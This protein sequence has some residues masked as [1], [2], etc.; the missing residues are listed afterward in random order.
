MKK[1]AVLV[2]AH[3]EEKVI[4]DTLAS[5]RNVVDAED[6]YVVDDGS[7]DNTSLK[8]CEVVPNV[9]QLPVNVGK[10]VASNIAIKYYRLFD[11]YEYLLPMDADTVITETFINKSMEVLD[12][13]IGKSFACSVGKVVGKSRNWITAFRLW[14]YEISQTIH[15]SAQ[16]AENAIIV[17]PG[18][19]TIW[20]ASI[21]KYV[22]V[23]TGTL[24]EDMDLTFLVHRKK[25]GKIIYVSSAVVVT[26]DPYTF[27]DFLKQIDRWYLGFWQCIEKHNIP[28]GGQVLD[29]E[30]AI[31]ALEGLFNGVLMTSFFVL[32][33]YSIIKNPQVLTY[34]LMIDLIFFMLPTMFL[35]AIRHKLWKIFLY[36]P[37]FYM[38]R[39]ISSIIFLKSFIKVVGGLDIGMG[40]NKVKRYTVA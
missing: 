13:D 11:E 19:S 15:K 9:L 37:Q 12:K 20:R 18:C 25:L 5:L 21:F 35:T 39:F 6:I 30:V 24:T 16:S 7:H 26:Q 4:L 27:K 8:A 32:L 14:E 3:N 28:W 22:E 10:A 1:L 36:I 2:P 33:P 29:W 38:M 17:C 34:P 40:W 31:L 23:P